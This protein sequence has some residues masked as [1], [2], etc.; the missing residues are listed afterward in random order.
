MISLGGFSAFAE[1]TPLILPA[2][3]QIYSWKNACILV[4]RKLFQVYFVN[5]VMEMCLGREIDRVAQAVVRTLLG[6]DI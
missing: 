4:Q 2:A 1:N 5:A 3:H 6:K